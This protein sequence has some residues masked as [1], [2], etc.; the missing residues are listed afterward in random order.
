MP[1]WTSPLPP[2]GDPLPPLNNPENA[3]P[4]SADWVKAIGKET[5]ARQRRVPISPN[6]QYSVEA[7][8]SVSDVSWPLSGAK[9]GPWEKIGS[10]DD[11]DKDY[12]LWQRIYPSVSFQLYK[13]L[14]VNFA[15]V[16]KMP[17]YAITPGK[18][19]STTPLPPPLIFWIKQG[20]PYETRDVRYYTWEESSVHRTAADGKKSYIEVAIPPYDDP[21][22]PDVPSPNGKWGDPKRELRTARVEFRDDGVLV[23]LGLTVKDAEGNPV[24]GASVSLEGAPVGITAKNGG[25][26]FSKFFDRPATEFVPAPAIDR[27]GSPRRKG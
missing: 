1:D 15:L 16:Q 26:E 25:L 8:T 23:A 14:T 4:Q 11:G 21:D 17:I 9:P 10:K 22:F 18:V 3:D 19:V 13:V 27:T 6:F 7:S 5:G 2:S 24:R 20:K 12:I